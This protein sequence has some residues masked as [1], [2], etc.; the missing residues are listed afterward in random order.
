VHAVHE[1]GFEIVQLKRRVVPIDVGFYLR[2]EDVLGRYPALDLETDFGTL[3]LEKE[4]PGRKRR[5]RQL[6]EVP[7]LGY[8]ERQRELSKAIAAERAAG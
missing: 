1:L 6:R 3:V 7:N 2:F 8:L 5:G 4:G